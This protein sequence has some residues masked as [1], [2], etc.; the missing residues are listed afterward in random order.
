MSES[1]PFEFPLWPQDH[2]CYHT[3]PHPRLTVYRAS[4]EYRTGQFVVICPG[5]A[6]SGLATNREGHRPAQFLASHGIS[7]AVLEYRVAPNRYP[8]PQSDAQRAI[9]LVRQ[10]ADAWGLSLNQVGIM[11]FSAGGHLAGSV[12]LLPEL[13]ESRAQDEADTLS[14]TPDFA[15]LIYPVVTLTGEFAHMGS[16]NNLLGEHSEEKAEQLSLQNLVHPKA[17]PFFMYHGGADMLVPPQNSFL[18]IDQLY[19]HHHPVDLYL[20]AGVNHGEG[21]GANQPWGQLL[22]QWLSRQGK[23]TH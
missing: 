13:Q 1:I 5:G 23:S 7:A 18:L 6:Y 2:P 12:A 10:Q 8:L 3:H 16:R 17:P 14:S 21:L 9:R 19:R 15:I 11:G 22:I 20:A 4:L